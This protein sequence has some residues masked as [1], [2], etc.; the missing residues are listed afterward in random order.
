MSAKRHDTAVWRGGLPHDGIAMIDCCQLTVAPSAWAFATQHQT[1][2]DAHWARRRA[3][4]PGFFNGEIFMLAGHGLDDGVFSGELLR[5]DFKSFLYWRETGH[6]DPGVKDCF[7]SALLRSAEGHILL[8]R[9]RAGN[10]NAGL[11]YLPGG[12]IDARDVHPDGTIDIEGS[13]AR[14]VAEETGLDATELERVAGLILTAT[15]PM[16][17]IA[18]EHRSRLGAAALRARILAHIATDP[19]SELTEVVVVTSRRDLDGLAMPAYA[20]ILLAALLADR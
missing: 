7:G 10:I 12:F 6:P 18:A 4:N 11:A 8:G 2:I 20:S 3:E 15:G 1:D 14:E 9:Q 17:S 13:I 16:I 5:T 19:Q